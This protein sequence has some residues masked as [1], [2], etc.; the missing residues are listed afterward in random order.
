MGTC[1][2]YPN[3][4]LCRVSN[5]L[6]SDFFRALG[7]V[8]CR[9]PNKIHSTNKNTWQRAYLSS[10][11]FLTLVKEALCQVFFSELGKENFFAEC[12]FDTRRIAFL[13]S[14]K[15]LRKLPL[16]RVFFDTR[17]SQILYHILKL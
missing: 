14:V 5:D 17:R 13:P 4:A 10:V 8:L 6:P 2:H 16:C 1:L 9:V 15:K 3:S 12:F 7:K 11:V